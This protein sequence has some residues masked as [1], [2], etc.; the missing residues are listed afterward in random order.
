MDKIQEHYYL[1]DIIGTKVTFNGK[2]IGTLSDLAIHAEEKTGEIEHI[3]VSR[4]FGD[5][6]LF[7]PW[8]FVSSFDHVDIKIDVSD[9]KDYEIEPTDHDVLL[10]DQVVDKRIIDIKENEVEVVYDIKLTFKE[11]RLFITDV[12]L[13]KFRMFK[14]LGLRAFGKILQGFAQFFAGKMQEK[15]ISWNF[16]QPLPTRMG[17]FKGDIKLNI[18]KENLSAIHPIDLAHILEEMSYYQRSTIFKQLTLSQASQTLE[19]IDPSL[20]R[21]IVESLTKENTLELFDLMTPGQ[22]ADV[23]SSLPWD[24][25][26][27]L[28]Q[29]LDDDTKRKVQAMLEKQDQYVEN[30]ITR[31]IIKCHKNDLVK[32]IQDAYPSL[33]K[34]KDVTMYLYIVNDD[35]QLIGVVDI[36]ELLEAD[37]AKILKDIMK[38]NLEVLK[39]KSTYKEAAEIFAKYDFRAIPVVDT[40]RKLL[41]AIRYKDLVKFKKRFIN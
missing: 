12:D 35:E 15:T 18:L 36:M 41:G 31:K 1:T 34:H 4:R 14:R 24:I 28:I 19:A 30:L 39:Q 9:I 37:E 25:S 29:L 22:I 2:R 20:Q 33:A 7:I 13:S 10:K 40:H 26:S 5:P 8:K 23:L 17:P 32:E 3:C 11:G 16:I 27:P 21:S 6:S 38:K